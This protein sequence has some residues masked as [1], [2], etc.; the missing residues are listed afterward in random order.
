M[1]IQAV[2]IILKTLQIF[3]AINIAVF[4]LSV[5]VIV[6]AAFILKQRKKN[7]FTLYSFAT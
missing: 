7:S 2:H 5:P 1:N 4:E 3:L 6:V